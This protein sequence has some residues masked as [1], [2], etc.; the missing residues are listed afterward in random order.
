MAIWSRKTK[1]VRLGSAL[2]AL[3]YTASASAECAWVLWVKTESLMF[4]SGKPPQESRQW[5]IQTAA[6]RI[7]QCEEVKRKIWQVFAKE[8]DDPTKCKGIED[9]QKV[10]NEGVFRRFKPSGDLIAGSWN[11]TLVCL[12]D[13]VDPRR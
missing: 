9:F 8:C 4:Y 2:V 5:E 7:D 13:T 12:P 3:L 11:T 6:P 10:P 1:L